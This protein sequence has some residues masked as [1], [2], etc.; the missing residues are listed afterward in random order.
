MLVTM[1]ENRSQRLHRIRL[2]LSNS[3]ALMILSACSVGC[4]L[5]D[6][7]KYEGPKSD[8]FDGEVFINRYPKYIPYTEVIGWLLNRNKGPQ[9]KWVDTV[10]GPPPPRRVDDLRV[11]FINHSTTLVQINGLNILTDPVWSDQVG[12]ANQLGP[13]RI[14][15]PGIRLVDL[16]PIDIVLISHNHYDHL[17]LPTLRTLARLHRPKIYLPLGNKALLDQEKIPGGI[18]LDWWQSDS[19]EGGVSIVGVPATHNSG[20]GLADID[21]NLWSGFVISTPRGNVYFAGDT[22]WGPHFEEIAGRFGS[23]RL[24]LLPIGAYLPRWFMAPS[25]IDPQDAMRAHHV[26]KA[27]TSL[28]IHFGTFMQSDEGEFEPNKDIDSIIASAPEPKPQFWLL[29]QGEGRD[30]PGRESLEAANP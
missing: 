1:F 18:D 8:H 3:L 24:A 20:R 12:P 9:R 4:A 23:L 27:Q 29:R 16:P 2:W 5:F 28:G 14:R 11:T 10:P 15:R 21:E 25:H 17:D 6:A 22:G 7:P 30:V 13:K 26:L 19:L